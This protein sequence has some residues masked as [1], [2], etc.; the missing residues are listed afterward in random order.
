MIKD[1]WSLISKSVE[2][3]GCFSRWIHLQIVSW[4][5]AKRILWCY[6][7][8]L[9]VYVGGLHVRLLVSKRISTSFVIKLKNLL[10]RRTSFSANRRIKSS[11]WL[12][13]DSWTQNRSIFFEIIGKFTTFVLDR[14]KVDESTR[15]IRMLA[16]FLGNQRTKWQWE[17]KI[18]EIRRR[19]LTCMHVSLSSFKF[20]SQWSYSTLNT[21]IFS[22]QLT[23]CESHYWRQ[24]NPISQHQRRQSSRHERFSILTNERKNIE[25]FVSF[26]SS[27]IFI[28]S[29]LMWKNI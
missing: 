4:L 11:I 28:K 5:H 8:L 19:M 24:A 26:F 10:T 16:Y 2:S 18:E 25:E 3:H 13:T 20:V 7:Y 17:R 29:S 1:K 23:T 22:F 6:H 21:I 15:T 9:V 27:F 14:V 12:Q